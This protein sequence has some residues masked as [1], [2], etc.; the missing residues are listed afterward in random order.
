MHRSARWIRIPLPSLYGVHGILK[1][2]SGGQVIAIPSESGVHQGDP[3]GSTLFALAL[4]PIIM[5]VA[6]SHS[7]VLILAYADNVFMIGK[8][9]S[10]IEMINGRTGI[11]RLSAFIVFFKTEMYGVYAGP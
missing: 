8:I 5:K 7:D 3:L 9:C 4:H 2:Y 11:R 6:E 1:Y 10:A